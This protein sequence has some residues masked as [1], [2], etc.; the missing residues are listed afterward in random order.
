VS[1]LR[2]FFEQQGTGTGSSQAETPESPRLNGG[3]QKARVKSNFIPVS[4]AMSFSPTENVEA[5]SKAGPTASKPTDAISE[6]V[7]I[8]SAQ[9]LEEAKK[10]K[11]LEKGE[12]V[13]EPP[14]NM[15]HSSADDHPKTPAPEPLSVE[16]DTLVS[17][18]LVA[19]KNKKDGNPV[20]N[21]VKTTSEDTQLGVSTTKSSITKTGTSSLSPQ[22]AATPK[23]PAVSVT[24]KPTPT[25]ARR[26]EAA[27][28]PKSPRTPKQTPTTAKPSP[29][30]KKLVGPLSPT[31][32]TSSRRSSSPFLPSPTGTKV[33]SQRGSTPS[34]ISTSSKIPTP[35]SQTRSESTPKSLNKVPRLNPP[36][37]ATTPTAPPQANVSQTPAKTTPHA[38][39]VNELSPPPIR[40]GQLRPRS[41]QGSLHAGESRRIVS[42]PP[43]PS[44]S[45]SNKP[46]PSVNRSA[47]LRIPSR[48]KASASILPPVPPV[49]RAAGSLS[50]EHKDYSHLPTFMRP[51]QA[52]SGK[53]V[54][55]PVSTGDQKRARAGSFKV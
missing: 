30:E 3:A 11:S 38:T 55:K 33:A 41:A 6:P 36:T 37:N 15:P 46:S 42:H 20:A 32:S 29:K 2:A 10:E 17:T 31:K 28:T 4:R 39:P 12:A 8:E 44:T 16:S 26:N 14:P 5:V 34:A 45:A 40:E 52:S 49:A 48:A 21:K 54:P 47:S 43:R 25:P 50:P 13:R 22:P 9:E 27:F 18:D 24:P 23:K 19:E 51:T 7:K 35:K 53:V 1:S